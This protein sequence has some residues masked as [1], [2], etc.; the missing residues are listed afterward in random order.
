MDV[1]QCFTA[2]CKAAAAVLGPAALVHAGC[3]RCM[4]SGACSEGVQ[5]LPACAHPRAGSDDGRVF[6][7]DAASGA[8]VAA[9]RADEDVANCV[10]P[11]PS[12]PVLA[13]SGIESVVRLWAPLAPAQRADL[14]QEIS[15]NQV[16]A[17]CS[18]RSIK[19]VS[20]VALLQSGGLPASLIG[21]AS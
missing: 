9:L 17:Q 15:A 14:L 20:V 18:W 3:R 12:L 1:L 8:A 5:R 4:P 6:I 2:T 13:T 16:R 11:H 10:A 21:A 19:A 7:Y